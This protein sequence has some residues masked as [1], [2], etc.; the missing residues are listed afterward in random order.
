MSQ[1][2]T[3]LLLHTTI[4]ITTLNRSYLVD[5]YETVEELCKTLVL[6]VC[7]PGGQ[8][9]PLSPCTNVII[10]TLFDLPRIFRQFR[11]VESIAKNIKLYHCCNVKQHWG[12]LRP[13]CIPIRCFVN[14]ASSFVIMN[15]Q[16]LF[17]PRA[18]AGGKKMHCNATVKSN[19]M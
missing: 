1:R 2:I 12:P 7:S 13:S 11:V 14:S 9:M 17:L 8:A 19:G 18:H 3:I 5:V 16:I 10:Q 4:A 15:M 6:C